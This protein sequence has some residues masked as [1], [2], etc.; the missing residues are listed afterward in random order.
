MAVKMVK[1]EG[2][3][4]NPVKPMTKRQFDALQKKNGETQKKKQKRK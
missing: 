4:K 2:S 1:I 3:I